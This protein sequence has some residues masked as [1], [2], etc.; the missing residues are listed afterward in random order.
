MNIKHIASIV[1]CGCLLA[2]TVETHA[3]IFDRKKKAAEAA[4]AA[5]KAKKEKKPTPYEKLFKDK[6]VKT[7]KGLVTLHKI[8]GKVYFEFP[9][10]LFEKEMLLG[11]SVESISDN[12]EAIVGQKPHDPLHIVFSNID[13]AVQ[14][15]YCFRNSITRPEDKQIEEAIVK[16]NIPAVLKSFKIEAWSPDSTAV[17]FDATDF[18]VSD[19]EDIDPF[20]PYGANTYFGWMAR[21]TSF[22]SNR[23]FIGD[24]NSYEDNFSISSHLS[25]GVTYRALGIFEYQTDKPFTAVMRRT[26]MLLPENKMKPRIADPRIGVF[27]TGKMMFTSTDNGMKPVYYAN[28]FRLEPSDV[29]AWRRGEKVEPVKPIVFYIDNEFPDMWK[30]YIREGIEGW[31][32]AFEQIGFKN[33]VQTKPFP[34]NDPEF[35]ANN[36]KYSCVNYAPSLTENAMGP[37]WVDPRTGEILN[38]SVYIYHNLVNVLYYWRFIQ[39]AQTDPAVRTKNFSEE[40]LGSAIRYVA[41][42]EVGHCLG[43]MHNMAASHAFPVDSLRSPSFTQKYGTTPSIMDYARFNYIA[44]PGD[45]ERGVKLTPPELGVYDLYAIKWLY[46]PLPDAKTPEEEVPTLSGWISEKAGDPLYRYGKQQIYSYYDPSAQTEDLGDNAMQASAYG[47]KNLKLITGNLNEWFEK[48]DKDCEFRRTLYYE[49]VQQL[50]R[51]LDH[52]STNIGGIYLNERYAGDPNP[53]YQTV[54]KEQQKEALRFLLD[55]QKDLSWLDD[56]KLV[57]NFEITGPIGTYMQNQIINQLIYKTSD[58][59]FSAIKA[60]KDPYTE[61]EYLD[62]IVSYIMEP[63]QKGKKLSDSERKAQIALMRTLITSSEVNQKEKRNSMFGATDAMSRWLESQAVSKFDVQPFNDDL[64]DEISGF[65][66]QRRIKYNGE[67]NSALYYGALLNMKRILEK[68]RFSND[69]VTRDHYGFMLY[70]INNALKIK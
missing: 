55:V 27:P 69:Q 64:P 17:V 54:S 29:E 8:D 61:Q 18:L 30:K 47:I 38:A 70:K 42:H 4:A 52:V 59:Q 39:T 19:L 5:E 2:S 32:I 6:K 23:S 41:R 48:D 10:N 20:D 33:A 46:S 51:Y 1:L 3:G 66:F 56:E 65:G 37:S 57:T 68:A 11:S 34:E 21:I 28:H 24:I 12:G 43:L 13:S 58:M 9:L 63:T 49:I 44:Q 67:N 31:N 45:L 62:D 50:R 15:R 22:K 14:I 16:S 25:F 53:T 26:F 60:E 35:S 7:C 36:L 40:V